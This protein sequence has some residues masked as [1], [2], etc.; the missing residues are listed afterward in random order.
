MAVVTN[1]D[2]FLKTTLANAAA[3]R[4]V[5]AAA[6]PAGA[7]VPAAAGQPPAPRAR[8]VVFGDS[9]EAPAALLDDPSLTLLVG[10][11]GLPRVPGLT[12]CLGWLGTSQ[13]GRFTFV[14]DN[15]RYNA[16][17]L[18]FRKHHGRVPEGNIFAICG[19]SECVTVDHM[20]DRI[21]RQAENMKAR[22]APGKRRA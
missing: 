8:T 3:A 15:T 21:M 7:P 13:G 19:R 14:R 10:D 5:A 18:L 1:D 2:D 22:T 16:R 9:R 4:A 20:R 6:Q 12:P 11:I 17:I